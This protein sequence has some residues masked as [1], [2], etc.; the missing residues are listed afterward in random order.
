MRLMALLSCAMPEVGYSKPVVLEP[1]TRHFG[2]YT[3]SE[4]KFRM[5]ISLRYFRSSTA[6]NSHARFAF[7]LA[8]NTLKI[9][10]QLY[11]V[12]GRY[13]L[14]NKGCMPISI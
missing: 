12:L 10:V 13:P 6:E 5:A 7:I 9:H 1:Y 2:Q 11:M 8:T 3:E 4:G 14:R